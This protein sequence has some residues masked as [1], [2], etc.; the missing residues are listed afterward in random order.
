MKAKR[1]KFTKA[2]NAWYKDYTDTFGGIEPIMGI[3][4]FETRT[5]SWEE[6]VAYNIRWITDWTQEQTARLSD[7]KNSK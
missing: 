6:F 2:Q 5:M 3:E 1:R 4:E 7:H